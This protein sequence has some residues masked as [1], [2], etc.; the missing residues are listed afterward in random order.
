MNEDN[1]GFTFNNITIID[2]VI[3]KKFKNLL[4]KIKI[5]NEIEFYRYIFEN[6]IS[7]PMPKIVCYE[8][9]AL[10]LQYINN[11]STLTNKI[12]FNNIDYYINRIKQYLIIIHNI[13][14]P[15]SFDII[16]RDLDIELHK[17]VLDRFNEFDWNSNLLFN[18]IKTVNN[19]KIRNTYE[20]CNLIRSK[21]SLY[22]KSR[23]HYNLI[24]G[25][26]HL[27]NILLDETNNIW[28]IDP[29]G[30][31]GESKLFGLYEYDYAKL[32]FGI[33]GYSVFD[34]MTINELDIENNNI[35]I[36]FIKQYEFIFESKLFDKITLLFCLSIWLAN[37]SCFSNIN[38]KIT[39]LMI[40]YYY[41]EKYI[42]CC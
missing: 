36:S 16:Q 35:E 3:N 11:S 10:S 38:K 13:Q 17:K 37:N 20:Y 31:F 1:Y 30:Y 28:F 41:C 19:V 27:G 22:L 8:D 9:G 42:D 12:E 21:I 18:S 5:N 39:S 6:N 15:M 23:N 34:N 7:F 32:M 24:H 25:D 14:I 4:G 26:V 2:N 29:R 33:S 40:A